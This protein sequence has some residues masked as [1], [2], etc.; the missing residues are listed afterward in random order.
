M[1]FL[2]AGAAP[3]QGH[4]AQQIFWHSAFTHALSEPGLPVIDA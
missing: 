3:G 1:D 4:I 2:E